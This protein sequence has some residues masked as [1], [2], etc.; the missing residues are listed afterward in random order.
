MN[1]R[2]SLPDRIKASCHKLASCFPS[3]RDIFTDQGPRFTTEQNLLLVSFVIILG[4]LLL[5]AKTW[6]NSEINL[7]TYHRV[8][9]TRQVLYDAEQISSAVKDLELGVRGY[10][11][12]GDYTF[13]GP[14]YSTQ[15]TIFTRIANLKS[16]SRDNHLQQARLDTLKVL[17]Q[18]KL[19]FLEQSIAVRK[20]DGATAAEAFVTGN[21]G[22]NR[23]KFLDR[24][25][26]EI[27][28]EE[29]KNLA[30]RKEASALSNETFSRLNIFLAALLILLVTAATYILWKNTQTTTKARILLENNQQLLQAIID[31]TSSI[32][33][34]KDIYGRFTLINRQFEKTYGLSAPDVVGKTVFDFNNDTYAMEYA[35]NDAEVLEHR[36]LIEMEEE[37]FIEGQL[38][39]YYSIKFPLID[40]NGDVYAIAG[41]STDITD[42]ILKQKIQQ[43]KEIVEH[44]LRTQENERKE[45]GLELHDNISQLLASAKMMLDT[46]LRNVERKDERLEKARNDV[47]TAINETRKLSH[48]LVSPL[49]DKQ[50]ITTAIQD[51]T[52]DLNLAA[53][54]KVT[55]A[56]NGKKLLNNLDEKLK[57]SLYRIIQEQTHNIVKY[58][59]ASNVSISLKAT[60]NAVNL[61]IEDDGIGFD[62]HGKAKGIGLQNIHNRVTFYSGKL[63][64]ISSPGQGCR[65]LVEIPSFSQPSLV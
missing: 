35:R 23:I 50:E 40:R 30:E 27:K 3:F 56:F 33:Y 17:L 10:V 42:I 21:P 13:L 45:I 12:T 43:Q 46:A 39:H 22:V 38:H 14:F 31:N 52:N 1:N 59:Q 44:T 15:Q 65:L 29:N 57:I 54:M 20:K 41:V 64:I 36:K 19:A 8:D 63:D 32:I 55:V 34:V 24:I 9:H 7:D 11:I 58:A 51:L 47:F 5:G 18:K 26:E 25:I 60:P 53:R 61:A 37:G 6:Q 4:I 62:T 48:S 16:L 49:L 28:T 2:K